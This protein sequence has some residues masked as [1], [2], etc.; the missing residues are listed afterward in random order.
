RNV[1]DAIAQLSTPE[2]NRA[3]RAAVEPRH[4][5]VVFMYP[6]QGSQ[7][8]RMGW[9]LYKSCAV[10]RRQVDLCAEL[11]TPHLG[12]DLRT[13][14][15]PDDPELESAGAQLDQ[16]YFSQPS[17]F[18]I[19]YA[20]TQLWLELGIKP[21]ATIGHS[22]GEY[23]SA[24]VAGVFSLED[25]LKLVAARGRLMQG[26]PKGTMLI[27]PLAEPEVK[28][29]LSSELAIAAVNAPSLCV[30]SGPTGAI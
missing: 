9:G 4:R 3:L 26:M 25:A 17:L 21:A 8:V 12:L 1:E 19:E 24:C 29:L 15:Y 23:V 11:L 20:L 18:V 10:F 5:P 28:Q 7:H 16:T 13:L 30:V 22:I 2:S 6:G 14:L 27:V